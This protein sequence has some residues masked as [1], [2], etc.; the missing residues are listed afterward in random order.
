MKKD[1]P[2]RLQVDWPSCRARGLCHEVLPEAIDLDPWGY[3]VVGGRVRPELVRLAREAVRACP[4]SALKL[5]DAPQP[6]SPPPR[7]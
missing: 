5:R 1:K 7:A 6:S 4:V 3:P 2:Q